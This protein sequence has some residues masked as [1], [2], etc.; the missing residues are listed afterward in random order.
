HSVYNTARS[1]NITAANAG[2]INDGSTTIAFSSFP[3]ITGGTGG[4]TFNVAG[5]MTAIT[6]IGSSGNPNTFNLNS[7]TVTTLTGG[8]FSDTFNMNGGAIGTLVAGSGNADTVNY[9]AHSGSIAVNLQTLAATDIGSFSGVNNFIG[10]SNANNLF[11]GSN[12]A[13]IWNITTANAAN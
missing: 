2:N 6:G 4:D 8:N 9:S 10:N 11:T 13:N 12:T 7:G 3:N 1:G 5:N